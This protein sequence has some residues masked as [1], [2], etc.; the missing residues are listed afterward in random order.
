MKPRRPCLRVLVCPWRAGV[1][2][3]LPLKFRNPL[4]SSPCFR[5]EVK[6]GQHQVNAAEYMK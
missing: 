3:R 2:F 4:T 5:C 6:S 1:Q